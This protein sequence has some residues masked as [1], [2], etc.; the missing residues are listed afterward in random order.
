LDEKARDVTCD[1]YGVFKLSGML[2]FTA[3]VQR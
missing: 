3:S 2:E 1:P